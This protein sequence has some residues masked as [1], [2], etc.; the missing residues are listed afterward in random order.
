[1]KDGLVSHRRTRCGS[2]CG[3]VSLGGEHT[4]AEYLSFGSET[5]TE[6][7]ALNVKLATSSWCGLLRFTVL[8]YNVQLIFF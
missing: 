3:E 1:M 8:V 5:G 4:I 2:G 6:N 7:G